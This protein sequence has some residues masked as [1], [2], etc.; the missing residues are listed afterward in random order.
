M[1]AIDLRCCPFCGCHEVVVARTNPHACW[2]RCADCGS[3][4]A[5]TA[6]R[7]LAFANWNRRHYDD[8]PATIVEDMDRP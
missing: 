7:K 4:G 6:S 5:P 1:K 2:V 3:E 8:T